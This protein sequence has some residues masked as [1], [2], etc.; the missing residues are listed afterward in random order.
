MSTLDL[1]G[2]GG[3]SERLRRNSEEARGIAQVEP[4]LDVI[5]LGP[6]DRYFPIRTKRCNPLT[7]PPVAIAGCY[8]KVR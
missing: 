8:T 3:L 7:G 5:S 1:A 2:L 6:E 4:E